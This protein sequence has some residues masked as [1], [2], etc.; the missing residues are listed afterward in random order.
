MPKTVRQKLAAMLNEAY[1]AEFVKAMKDR[2][3]L[4]VTCE[5]NI[6]QMRL[7]SNRVDGK[8][9]TTAQ[10]TFAEGYSEGFAKAMALVS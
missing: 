4:D 7:I 8:R 9:F 2:Y 1:R 10:H 3:N 5:Y 6:F